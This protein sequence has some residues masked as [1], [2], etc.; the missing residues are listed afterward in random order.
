M[1]FRACSWEKELAQ[2][3]KDGH[4]PQGCGAELCAHVDQCGKCG[5]LVLVTQIFQSA[6]RESE[7]V[8]PVGGSSSLPS[9][10]LLWWRAQLRR[11]NAAAER[12]SRPITVA[13]AF[14]WLVTLLVGVIFVASEY[15]HGLGWASWWSELAPARAFHLLLSG[16]GLAGWN[17]LLV[18]SG[19]GVLALLSGLVVYLAAEKS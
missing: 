16:S 10:S 15:R 1:T 17:P 12:V 6:R 8:A 18:V 11:R 2:A 3:L 9:P 14:A 4:W 13:Q 19:F 7:R 5:D